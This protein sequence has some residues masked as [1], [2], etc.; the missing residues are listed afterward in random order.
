LPVPK[1][2]GAVFL[3]YHT[4]NVTNTRELPR[5][6]LGNRSGSPAET[7]RSSLRVGSVLVDMFPRGVVLELIREVAI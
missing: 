7:K 6:S 5:L 3:R 4:G 1:M 2:D